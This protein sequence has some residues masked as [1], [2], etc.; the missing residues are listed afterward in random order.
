MLVFRSRY[1]WSVA[2]FVVFLACVAT[3]GILLLKYYP[4]SWDARSGVILA[5]LVGE[6]LRRGRSMARRSEWVLLSDRGLEIIKKGVRHFLRSWDEIEDINWN[7]SC[8]TLVLHLKDGRKVKFIG[9]AFFGSFRRT[10]GF[11]ET[12][13]RRLQT[14][15][16][17]ALWAEAAS[18]T[19]LQRVT[20]SKKQDAR[21]VRESCIGR[22]CVSVWRQTRGG[23]CVPSG[24]KPLGTSAWRRWRFLVTLLFRTLLRRLTKPCRR[25]REPKTPFATAPDLHEHATRD[26]D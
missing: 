7:W 22:E 10:E 9:T 5:V 24:C 6:S 16:T 8:D 17:L 3:W 2:S 15:K 11:I 12:F 19:K 4:G 23:I 25:L 26:D 20:L 13:R 14:L 18:G 1:G 21:A